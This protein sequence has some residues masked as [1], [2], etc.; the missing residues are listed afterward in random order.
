MRTI[1]KS[2]VKPVMPITLCLLAALLPAPAPAA[3]LLI[4]NGALAAGWVDNW[5]WN[6]TLATDAG[7]MYNKADSLAVSFT[8]PWAGLSFEADSPVVASGFASLQFAVYGAAGSGQLKLYTQTTGT[9]TAISTPYLFTPAANAWTLVQV[10]M[11][12]LGNPTQIGRITIQDNSGQTQPT[13]HV[14]A[15]TL[16]NGNP[17]AVSLS[18]DATAARKAI[19]PDIYGINFGDAGLLQELGIA[20]NRWGGNNT[21]RYNWQLDV[22]NLDDDWYFE[23]SKQSNATNLPADS[24]VNRFIAANAGAAAASLVT[25]PMIGYVSKNGSLA[26]CGFSIAKYGAQTGHDPYRP[27]CGN[28]VKAGGGY[29]TGNSPLDT[30]IAVNPA[31]VQKWVGYLVQKYGQAANGGVT[32]YNLDN[33][34]DIWFATQ[35]DVAPVGLTYD[36]LKTLTIQYA[37][38]VKAADPTAMTLGPVVDG[39]TYYFNSPHDGQLQLWTTAPDRAAHGGMPLV[40]WYLQQLHTYQI[41]HGVRLLDYLD[42][43]YYPATANVSLQPAGSAATQA[44]RLESTR[45]LW[46]PGYVDQSWIASAGPDNGII[47][48]IPRMRNWVNTYYPGTRL[49]ITEYNWGAPESINGALAQADVLGIFGREGLDLATLWS[50]PTADQPLA[51]AFRLYRNYDG[52]GGRFGDTSVSAVSSNQ[53]QLAVYAAE[54]TGNGELTL[55]I[56]NKTAASLSAPLTLNHFTASGNVQTWRYSPANLNQIVRLTDTALT[57]NKLTASYPANSITLLIIPGQHT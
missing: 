28:G 11:A 9:A 32:F 20:V 49:A 31:F 23:N 47:Q 4:Y 26:T 30:S 2:P 39:W 52:N 38:A 10:P 1:C 27:N 14:A 24:A 36:Q 35:R 33:E 18:I 41:N 34:P 21:S 40:P 53:A 16:V 3:N 46:D 12:K 5:G 7:L 44:L 55:M 6:D 43:H 29:V 25:V 22:S 50:P 56:I 17:P 54:N 37:A 42:L 15:L 48:L 19:S 8:A 57:G 45:S 13:F 51:Y